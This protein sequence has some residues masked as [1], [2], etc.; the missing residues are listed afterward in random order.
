MSQPTRAWLRIARRELAGGLGGFWIYLACLALGAWAIAAAGSITSSFNAGLDQQSRQLLGGD[1]AVTLTQRAATSEERAWL[2]ERGGRDRS[3]AGRPD[4]PRSRR[5]RKQVDVRGIDGTFP[6]VG[7]FA[8]DT[9]IALKDVLERRKRDVGD[10]CS[11]SL[12]KDLE[13]A[14]G[15]RFSLGEV[16]VEI[17]AVLVREPDRIGEPGMFEPRAII[18]SVALRDAG[19]MQPGAL[20]RTAYRIIL[21][22]EAAATFRG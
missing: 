8:F 18:S 15:D 20:F 16:K 14:V 21:K 9:P 5:N 6:L 12:L 2:D 1:A 17:R 22:P 10:R 11:E 13:L 4:G 7:A 19:L 3:G